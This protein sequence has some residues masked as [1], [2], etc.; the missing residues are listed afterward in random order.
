MEKDDYQILQLTRNATDN[1]ITSA[2]VKLNYCINLFDFYFH[3]LHSYHR[4]A[5]QF[6][7]TN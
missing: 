3:W 6:H 4:L 2:Y 5:L 7:P 1:D